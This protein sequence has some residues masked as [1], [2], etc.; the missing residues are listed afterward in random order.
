MRSSFRS[1]GFR[2]T[3]ENSENSGKR[4]A[5]TRSGHAFCCCVSGHGWLGC[6]RCPL[7]SAPA[8]AHATGGLGTAEAALACGPA[9]AKWCRAHA[10]Y[11][12]LPLAAPRV[13]GGARPYLPRSRRRQAE[14][15][16]PPRAPIASRVRA[17]RAPE[18]CSRSSGG[19]PFPAE[20]KS[21]SR[22]EARGECADG[23]D[24]CTRATGPLR[25]S[26]GA[27]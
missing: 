7:E 16:C 25:G 3:R 4:G 21:C 19:R 6:P 8:G 15:L 9:G 17:R 1:L 27:R 20:I 10:A 22:N 5:S 24:E 23:G 11:S 26:G 14:P 12:A 13:P 2:K 18:G